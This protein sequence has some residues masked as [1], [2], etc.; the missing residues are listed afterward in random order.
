MTQYLDADE[1]RKKFK[2]PLI[3]EFQPEKFRV[4]EDPEDLRVWEKNLRERVGFNLPVGISDQFKPIGT[5]CDSS[6]PS[7][8]VSG[9]NMDTD[10]CDAD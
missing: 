5:C 4:L 10:D 1:F 8:P 7:I 3:L 9:D 2:K 6:C